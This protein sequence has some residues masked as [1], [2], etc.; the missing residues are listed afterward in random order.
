MTN[1]ET[2][3]TAMTNI[4]TA[5]LAAIT[6]E[7]WESLIETYGWREV[8]DLISRQEWAD[9]TLYGPCDGE[10]FAMLAIAN[11]GGF[12]VATQWHDDGRV[13][14]AVITIAHWER[15]EAAYNADMEEQ[16][17]EETY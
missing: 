13:D 11:S 2:K 9:E 12:V 16:E 3:T 6:K 15:I 17:E 1:I 5:A 8:G 10:G 7:D 4:E 14:T